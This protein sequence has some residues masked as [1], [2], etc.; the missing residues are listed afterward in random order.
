MR[1]EQIYGE[2]GKRIGNNVKI[3]TNSISFTNIDIHEIDDLKLAN[4]AMKLWK[5]TYINNNK[6]KKRGKMD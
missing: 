3:V 2:K 1:L 5:R 6:N 4:F